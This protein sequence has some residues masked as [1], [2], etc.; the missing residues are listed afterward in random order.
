MICIEDKGKIPQLIANPKLRS[1]KRK[2][3]E[4]EETKEEEA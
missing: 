1:K 3:H 2:L 4:I